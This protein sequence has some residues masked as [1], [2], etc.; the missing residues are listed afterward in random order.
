MRHAAILSPVLALGAAL[1]AGCPSSTSG[2]LPMSQFADEFGVAA[3]D[4]VEACAGPTVSSVF[5]ASAGGCDAA[6]VAGYRNALLPIVE[7]AIDRGTV[8]YDP[9]AARACINALRA[10]PC[11]LTN[12]GSA[13]VACQDVWQ[14]TQPAGGAC[15]INEECGVEQFCSITTACPGTCQARRTSG[16]SCNEERHCAAGLACTDGMCVAPPMTGAGC[17]D[18]GG[19]GLGS[20]CSGGQCR[21]VDEV[22]IANEGQACNLQMG[23]LCQEGLSCVV[24]AVMPGVGA[25]FVC[26]AR[27]AAGAACRVGLPS[28][29]PEGQACAETDAMRLDFDGVCAPVPSTEGATCDTLSGCASGMRCADAVCMRVRENGETCTSGGQCASTTCTGGTCVA[30]MLCGS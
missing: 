5:F 9:A 7:Q 21:P 20:L 22:L 23:P 24:D 19:C 8:T 10:D 30:P 17:M 16:Q 1:A 2:G 13:A 15:S 28:Q 12:N 27:V 26:R 6:F 11:S 14:G 18:L 3:C 4:A 29:C 25:T